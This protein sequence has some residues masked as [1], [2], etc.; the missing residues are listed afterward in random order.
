LLTG[1]PGV[2]W[3]ALWRVAVYGR[4]IEGAE[5]LA[6]IL[7]RPTASQDDRSLGHESLMLLLLAQGRRAEA[8]AH[9][10][11]VRR[12]YP[13]SPDVGQIYFQLLGLAENDRGALARLRSRFESWIPPV[14]SDSQLF[15]NPLLVLGPQYRAYS[16]GLLSVALGEASASNAYAAKLDAMRSP[17]A[18]RD[19]A[20]LLSVVLRGSALRLEGRGGEA[21]AAV[22]RWGGRP[23]IELGAGL[24]AEPY[25][26]WLR[27]ELLR[28]NNRDA[29]ALGW[30]AS[31][32]DLFFPEVIYIAPA[33]LRMGEIH[34]RRGDKQRAVESFRTFVTLWRNADPELQP[35]VRQARDK[36]A[37]LEQKAGS[38]PA[39][40]DKARRSP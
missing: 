10:A 20:Q 9:G 36:I 23:P 40:S 25:Y 16:A 30:Y 1:D 17:T 14:A 29:E 5:R 18:A 4:N 2:T 22:E 12:A 15:A 27:A 32:T 21:L 37:H 19:I 33:A 28:E 35:F 24:G 6:R 11:R 13:W 8:V 31:R 38:P 39:Q 7:A 3:Q 26:G 34:E